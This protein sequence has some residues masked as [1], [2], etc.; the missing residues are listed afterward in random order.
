MRIIAGAAKGRSLGAPRH[1]TRPMT[2]R[3]R[4]SIFS[5]L[6]GR[7]PGAVVLDLFAGSGSLGLEALSRGASDAVF[8]EAGR[9]A[10]RILRENIEHV[11]LGGSA[12]EQDVN[13]FLRFE[14]SR[15]DLIFVDP[16]YEDDDEQVTSVLELLEPVLAPDGVVVLHRQARSVVE[17]PDFLRTVDE[18]R[19]GD[20]VMTMMERAEE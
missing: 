2:G 9:V 16:P 17:L 10:A 19:Y 14:V 1:G 8:V 5:I 18:R 20:A 7:L 11:G 13:R 12:L 6:S 3:A 4:E 15:Y